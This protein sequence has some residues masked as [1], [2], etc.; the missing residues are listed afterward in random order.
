MNSSIWYNRH[1]GTS[2]VVIKGAVAVKDERIY[3]DI[4]LKLGNA[5]LVLGVDTAVES[6]VRGLLYSVNVLNL[7]GKEVQSGEKT[8]PGYG[9]AG[10][11]HLGFVEF[12]LHNAG[13]VKELVSTSG[14]TDNCNV[15]FINLFYELKD[16][17]KILLFTG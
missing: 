8:H 15:G 4:A 11:L 2:S 13:M 7:A 9:N 3:K 5:A 14:A 6:V 16:G 10:F 1:N 17:V 12:G